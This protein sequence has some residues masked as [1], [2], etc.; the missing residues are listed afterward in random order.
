[1]TDRNHSR[2]MVWMFLVALLGAVAQAASST[3]ASS[4]EPAQ[5]GQSA[6]PQL[7]GHVSPGASAQPSNLSSGS[8]ASGNQQ[9]DQ[10]P[11]APAPM[12]AISQS[13]PQA[14]R[15]TACVVC[16]DEQSPLSI[17][18]ELRRRF[19]NPFEGTQLQ[20]ES[21][22]EASFAEALRRA[23]RETTHPTADR[24]ERRSF[25]SDT[26]LRARL[27][28][29]H[30]PAQNIPQSAFAGFS[31]S[32]L[33]HSGPQVAQMR[34]VAR[35]LDQLAADLEEMECYAQADE[36]RDIAHRLRQA[37]RGIDH[38]AYQQAEEAAVSA[39]RNALRRE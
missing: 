33:P 3:Q 38:A 27:F 31:P 36:L 21:V 19:G 35:E 7:Q 29:E 32:Q 8:Q 6:T 4:D 16:D 26:P 25:S 30:N 28:I 39:L 24:I 11:G 37:V 20:D 34:R 17:I 5:P 10:V 14:T 12:T 18:V 22:G 9:G 1:M 23:A 15:Q 13:L 2:R